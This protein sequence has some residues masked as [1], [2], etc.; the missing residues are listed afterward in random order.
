MFRI[1]LIFA[2]TVALLASCSD[3]SNQKLMTDFEV[4]D[5][6]DRIIL[7]SLA[8]DDATLFYEW[9]VD[10]D[11]I[12]INNTFSQ[13]TF[14]MLPDISQPSEVFIT[15]IVSDGN[16]EDIAEKL[17]NLPPL[18]DERRWG[19]GTM[20]NKGRSNDVE[21]EWYIDQM[22]TGIHSNLNCGPASVTMAIKWYDESFS[23]TTDDARNTYRS[24]GGW[25]YT[26]DIINYLNNNSVGNFTLRLSDI[27][28]IVT[29]IDKGNILILCLD[30]YYITKSMNDAW[31]VDKF[32]YTSNPDWGH[33]IVVKG[34]KQLD[35]N[36]LLETYDSY[37]F[38][39]CYSDNT[40]KGKN[41]YYRIEDIDRS[42]NIWWDY[43]IVISR[44][45][46]S[47][48]VGVDPA[49]IKHMY[50]R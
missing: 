2:L 34:Y 25:W 18:T 41:R 15:H 6:I 1:K 10:S 8:T 4:T 32:Y 35:G 5:G 11:E 3:D 28:S 13:E 48:G 17:I 50:G 43:A 49:S 14:F 29:E 9:Q 19:L 45:K 26:S 16:E 21:Y 33:F 40:L 42:T 46:V 36:M 44:G 7:T 22:N 23:G 30:M 39:S 12:E 31:R 47:K 20:I 24:G 37:S 38:G 27:N